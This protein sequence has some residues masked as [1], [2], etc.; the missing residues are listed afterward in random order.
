MA[1]PGTT[2][3]HSPIAPASSTDNHATHLEEY[4]QGGWRTVD[5]I[6]DRDNIPMSRR[7]ELMPVVVKSEKRVYFLDG[8]LNNSFW[9]IAFSIFP[10]DNIE[11]TIQFPANGNFLWEIYNPTGDNLVGC[12]ISYMIKRGTDRRNGFLEVR[13]DIAG[14]SVIYSGMIERGVWGTDDCGV[15]FTFNPSAQNY[16]LIRINVD[17]NN[18]STNTVFIQYKINKYSKI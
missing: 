1:I 3:V 17:V 4:G 12:D 8:G 15:I 14:S 16:N 5:T 7:K 13:S 18:M 10:T 6:T 11:G 9:K 2:T